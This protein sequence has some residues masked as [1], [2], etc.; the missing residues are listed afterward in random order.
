AVGN[1]KLEP[2]R[3]GGRGALAGRASRRR[4][5]V[6]VGAAALYPRADFRR[7]SDRGVYYGVE[8]TAPPPAAG[9][10]SR[11]GATA[12]TPCRRGR[13]APSPGVSRLTAMSWPSAAVLR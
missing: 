6:A 3:R 1:A 11:R 7:G 12:R 5:L 8:R 9:C 10:A 13:R 2:R 4:S